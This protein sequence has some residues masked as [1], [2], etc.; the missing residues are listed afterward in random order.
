LLEQ[1]KKELL[2][3]KKIR[4]KSIFLQ[5]RRQSCCPAGI[6]LFSDLCFYRVISK[7][8]GLLY[9]TRTTED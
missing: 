5:M 4:T 6:A 8:S 1:I 9:G 3:K 2:E 7:V